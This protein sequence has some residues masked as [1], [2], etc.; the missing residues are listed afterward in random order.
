M[1]HCPIRDGQWCWFAWSVWSSAFIEVPDCSKNRQELLTKSVRNPVDIYRYC[2]VSGCFYNEIL[3]CSKNG[4]TGHPQAFPWCCAQEA[5]PG[6]PQ[7]IHRCQRQSRP[8]LHSALGVQ[9]VGICAFEIHPWSF[10]EGHA[11]KNSLSPWRW[12]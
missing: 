3:I 5:P 8:A 11:F 6:H 10:A 2:I 4:A 9:I 12:E 7:L 1:R